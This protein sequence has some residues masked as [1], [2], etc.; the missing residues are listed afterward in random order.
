MATRIK[1][2]PTSSEVFARLVSCRDLDE[3]LNLGTPAELVRMLFGPAGTKVLVEPFGDALIRGLARKNPTLSSISLAMA[4]TKVLDPNRLATIIELDDAGFD[5]IGGTADLEVLEDDIDALVAPY[6]DANRRLR[7]LTTLW[8][9]SLAWCRAQADAD[10]F[11][12]EVTAKASKLAKPVEYSVSGISSNDAKAMVLEWL[13][14]SFLR[15]EEELTNDIAQGVGF[16]RSVEDNAR[17]IGGSPVGRERRMRSAT[18]LV[19]SYVRLQNYLA[20]QSKPP[21]N[22]GVATQENRWFLQGWY[23]REQPKRIRQVCR[24]AAFPGVSDD[25]ND[26]YS[27]SW[28]ADGR[29][30]R[31][32]NRSIDVALADGAV[33]R[34]PPPHRSIAAA[35]TEA[36]SFVRLGAALPVKPKDWHSF[37]TNLLE[38]YYVHG[39]ITIA[40]PEWVTNVTGKSLPNS[41]LVVRAPRD[42]RELSSWASY[43]GNCIHS[44]FG[45]A[46][47][48][49][50]RVI[51]GVFRGE[52]LLYN[53]GAYSH[54]GRVWE[55]N[56]R[57]NSSEVP[58]N[59]HPEVQQLI[60][61]SIPRSE[62][63]A[64]RGPRVRVKPSPKAKRQ[65]R[66]WT[67]PRVTAI[68]EAMRAEVL[69]GSLWAQSLRRL[70][71]GANRTGEQTWETSVTQLLRSD[72]ATVLRD[73]ENLIRSGNDMWPLLVVH[74]VDFLPT[75]IE[76][77]KAERVG[78]DQLRAGANDVKLRT[79]ATLLDDPTTN[80]AWEFGRLG[81]ELREVYR[82]LAIREPLEVAAMIKADLSGTARW[83]TAV[84]WVRHCDQISITPTHRGTRT[85]VFEPPAEA[86][87]VIAEQLNL[88]GDPMTHS[89]LSDWS[90]KRATLGRALPRCP[91]AWLRR[92]RAQ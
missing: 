44:I 29:L 67:F 43:M 16:L 68:G 78:L 54:N 41:D 82:K 81:G 89:D 18:T 4:C 14:Q 47:H 77:T 57:F 34:R 71:T 74:P 42:M 19:L 12:K 91:Q 84:L 3:V 92:N 80:A 38:P 83:V 1:I 52:T 61:A 13:V 35:I 37:L 15:A 75:K 9:E 7:L 64:K 53:V 36:A 26:A 33:Q 76:I 39:T 63:A 50:T 73:F 6:K 27:S 86:L 87:A 79:T 25:F 72:R 31:G 88:F 55:V 8:S 10:S 56:S 23:W 28:L 70:A 85:V 45:D 20:T 5:L 58:G 21:K 11:V 30:Y 32:M 90:T 46:V 49:G 40:A 65:L 17:L 22:P 51:L 59:I 62:L 66:V 48:D 24:L 69:P 60:L 2:G